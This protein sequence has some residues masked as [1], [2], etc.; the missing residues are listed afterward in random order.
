MLLAILAVAFPLA[1][2]GAH[3]FLDFGLKEGI[4]YEVRS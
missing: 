1:A 4:V 2:I 3:D